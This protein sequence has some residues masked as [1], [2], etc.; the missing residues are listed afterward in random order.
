MNTQRIHAL[1][2]GEPYF[3][4]PSESSSRRS[5]RFGER[6]FNEDRMQQYL[7]REAYESVKAAIFSGTKIDRKMANQ[8][9]EAMKAWAMSTGA[10]H[11]THWFQP[12]TG[13]TADRKIWR[14]PTGT[15]GTGRFQL[16]QRRHPQY[17]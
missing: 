7:T 10:T 15:A 17:L 6:V 2:Q 3:K 9:A 14:R 8:V 16:S 1:Q 5:E 4:A 13:A 12:L 11:Y